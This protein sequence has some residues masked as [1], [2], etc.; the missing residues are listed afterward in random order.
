MS[1]YNGLPF[2][3]G[4]IASILGQTFADFEFIIVDDGSNDGSWE[5]VQTAAAADPRILA[6]R[7]DVNQGY[8]ASQNRAISLAAGSL[9]ALQDQDDVSLPV[10]LMQQVRLLEARPW[11]GCVGVWPRFIDEHG[12]P[13]ESPTFRLLDRDD[14]IRAW[15]PWGPC[16]CGPSVLVRR[17]CLD[18]VGPYNPN[19]K[20]A[21]DYDLLLRLAES[22]RIENIPQHL[23]LYRQH[24]ASVSSRQRYQ[25]RLSRAVSLEGSLVRGRGIVAPRVL[26]EATAHSYLR[27][28]LVAFLEGESTGVPLCVDRAHEVAP[29]ISRKGNLVEETVGRYLLR[30]EDHEANARIER[31]FEQFLPR[32]AH[33]RR[34]QSR[35][36]ARA[37][38]R[39]AFEGESHKGIV[40]ASVPDPL[41]LAHMMAAVRADPH[42]LLNRGVWKIGLRRFLDDPLPSRRY[43]PPRDEL[44]PG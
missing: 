20:S 42:W 28:A 12:E 15:L 16:L 1:V 26:R 8:A 34:A 18:E 13:I 11:V 27:A 3:G 22:T 10:R 17:S 43:P 41:I 24:P 40:P 29:W 2:L 37:H 6:V 19:L 31:F 23:Y 44:R 7:H 38:I 5:S 32:T 36:A 14:D 9:I 4:A 33:L 35:L 39:W 21:E 25:Q 30:D